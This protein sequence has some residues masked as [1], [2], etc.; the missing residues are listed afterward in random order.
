MGYPL[1]RI[2]LP[3]GTLLFAEGDDGDAAYLVQAGEIEIFAIR[4]GIA[5][6]LARR[7]PGDIVGEMAVIVRGR[8][9]ASARVIVD[10]ILLIVTRAQISGRIANADPILRMCL[11]VLSDRYLQTASKLKQLNGAHPT[12]R[13]QP[14]SLPE[15]RAAIETLSLEADLRRALKA[16][17]IVVFFQPIVR[18]DT[19]RLVGFEAL[20]RW[21]H[22]KRGL[23]PPDD[24]IP[25]AEASGLIVEITSWLLG[26]AAIAIPE[27]RKAALHN[28]SATEPLFL[29]INVSGHDL[30]DARFE[31]RLARMLNES[32]IPANALKIEVTESTLMKDPVKAAET[33]GACRKLGVQVALDDFGTGYSSLSYL[34]KLPMTAI[35]IAP[36]F[37]RSMAIDPTNWT[38]IQMILR[39]AEEL[40]IPVIAEGVEE[41]YEAIALMEMGC[42]FGQGYLFG[43]PVPLEQTLDLIRGWI[44]SDQ[45]VAP[46]RVV[47]RRAA[48]QR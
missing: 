3:A 21:R 45:E 1:D 32:G 19:R 26:Q 13:A 25:I 8:R 33:L 5:L 20:A 9:S 43:R 37:V 44:A 46:I 17:E 42:A 14:V 31:G 28:V 40:H 35:K 10:C 24:F 36:S 47:G 11:G 34:S 30:V 4:K 48:I 29:S 6:S 15:F 16:H 38:I 18:F 23:V 41:P 27:I 22:P 12:A 39:L 7:G 2:E